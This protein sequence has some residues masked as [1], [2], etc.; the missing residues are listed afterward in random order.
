MKSQKRMNKKKKIHKH[1]VHTQQAEKMHRL[2]DQGFKRETRVY[3]AC[4]FSLCTVFETEKCFSLMNSLY[5]LPHSNGHDRCET[6]QSM[7][8]YA[9]QF[10]HDTVEK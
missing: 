9:C 10:Q 1:Q 8:K 5:I 7:T 3:L 6:S 4:N 2:Y